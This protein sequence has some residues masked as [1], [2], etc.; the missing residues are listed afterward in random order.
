VHLL[1]RNWSLTLL[2]FFGQPL[3]FLFTLIVSEVA[4]ES[5]LRLYPLCL[6][7]LRRGKITGR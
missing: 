4:F 2:F 3:G 6:S 5:G 1:V 7:V